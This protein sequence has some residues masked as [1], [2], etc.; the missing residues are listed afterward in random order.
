[1]STLA[2]QYALLPFLFCSLLL[3][4]AIATSS[5]RDNLADCNIKSRNSDDEHI[6]NDNEVTNL[7]VS[8]IMGRA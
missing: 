3:L 6:E 4:S 8:H 1:M 2:T 7:H 5:R